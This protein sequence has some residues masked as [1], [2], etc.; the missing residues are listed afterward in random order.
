MSEPSRP[1]ARPNDALPPVEPPSA[2]FLVQLFVVPA[3]IVTIIILVWAAIHWLA[4]LGNDP[5]GYVRALRRTNEGRWQV[6]F[7]LA[8]DLRGPGGAALKN[9]AGLAGELASILA[10][11]VAGGRTKA[12]GH[13]GEQ[14]RAL[15][16]YLC[17]ALGEFTV[18]EA[19][20]PLAA[21]AADAA[22]PQT[23]QA[24]VEALAVLADNLATAQRGFADPKAVTAAVLEA[25]RSDVDALRSAAAF[26]LGVVGGAAASGRLVELVDDA[27]DAVRYNAAIGLVRQGRPE[28]WDTCAE[29]LALPDVS[30][31]PGDRQAQAERYRRAM[32]VV[33]AIKALGRFVDASGEEPPAQIV[34]RV[35]ALRDDAAGDVRDSARA[36]AERIG[37]GRA[38][39]P[40][41]R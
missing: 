1:A 3:V 20:P 30:P 7:N 35:Q 41:D 40:A 24:A 23:A 13:G 28:A 8:G 36:L 16:G 14:A 29:M 19:A 31:Q 27:D 15:T 11:E 39:K 32:V 34:E 4:H 2:A 38:E 26:T 22:D 33:N 5:Q 6:A 25:S 21:R 17:R 12:A 37:R 9:D 10:D 18:P